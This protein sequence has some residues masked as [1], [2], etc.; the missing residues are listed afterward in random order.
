MSEKNQQKS[1]PHLSHKN[2]GQQDALTMDRLNK[3]LEDSRD[4]VAALNQELDQRFSEIAILT[5]LLLEKDQHSD[6][7][8]RNINEKNQQIEALQSL[9]DTL[10]TELELKSLANDDLLSLVAI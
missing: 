8:L 6:Q 2:I 3:E 9:R 10:T 1:A 7:L 5:R 4:Q